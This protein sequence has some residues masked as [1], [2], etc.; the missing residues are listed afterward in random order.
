[1]AAFTPYGDHTAR[2]I[3][4]ILAMYAGYSRRCKI[5]VGEAQLVSG[6]LL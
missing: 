3:K 2:V 4:R 5:H 1:M 6:F